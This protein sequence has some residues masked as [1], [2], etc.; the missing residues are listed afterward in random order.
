[1]KG[2]LLNETGYVTYPAKI[3]ATI[4]P[5]I[6]SLNW[7]ISNVECNKQNAYD[8]DIE[9]TDGVWINGKEL[10]KQFEA[11]PDVQWIW[12][13]LSG[14]PKDIPFDKICG[15]LPIDIQTQKTIPIW[16]NPIHTIEPLAVAELFAFD[17][18]K[19]YF[20]SDNEDVLEELKREYPNS[21]NLEKE[22]MA[23]ER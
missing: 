15:H 2:L 14:Y 23:N 10:M 22:N 1:M 6:E 7:R 9:S 4:K 21:V 16:N 17:S 5:Y 11:H 8:L 13:L 20:V 18:L 19:T 12:G 3:F